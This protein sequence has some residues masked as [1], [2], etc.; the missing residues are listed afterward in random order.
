M[1]DHATGTRVYRCV[2]NTIITC[3]RNIIPM[4]DLRTFGVAFG[5]SWAEINKEK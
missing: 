3:V 1:F 5:L 4:I 2:H